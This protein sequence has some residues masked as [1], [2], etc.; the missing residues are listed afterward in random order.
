MAMEVCQENAQLAGNKM[1]AAA[2][3]DKKQKSIEETYQKMTQLEHILLRPDTCAFSLVARFVGPR[4]S[5]FLIVVL[6]WFAN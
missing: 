4:L 1:L 3:T 2:K 6:S 5:W